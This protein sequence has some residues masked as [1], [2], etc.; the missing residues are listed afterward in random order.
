MRTI[1]SALYTLKPHERGIKETLGK[2][3]GFVMP[4]LGIQVHSSKAKTSSHLSP[5]LLERTMM[6]EVE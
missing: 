1:Y 3:D 6:L 5:S 2:Y 4:G